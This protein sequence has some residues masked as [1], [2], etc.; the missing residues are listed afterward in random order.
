MKF[1]LAML[2]T[3]T[4]LMLNNLYA[5][6][7]DS[8]APITAS[9][10][11]LPFEISNLDNPVSLKIGATYTYKC[12]AR[13]ETKKP[14]KFFS[15]KTSSES[16]RYLVDRDGRLY[17]TFENVQFPHYVR[18]LIEFKDSKAVGSPQYSDNVSMMR[19]EHR[20][21]L[22]FSQKVYAEQIANN[23]GLYNVPIGQGA[24]LAFGSVCTFN[25]AITRNSTNENHMVV[26]RT[27]IPLGKPSVDISAIVFQV[28][29]AGECTTFDEGDV[30]MNL[31][32]W[33]AV[34]VETGETIG[35]EVNVVTSRDGKQIS[36]T[37]SSAR[38]E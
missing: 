19:K 37:T 11:K 28:E 36:E 24:Q 31:K 38:C 23:D 14:G 21:K 5:A 2:A 29:G 6:D 18:A 13:N 27:Q 34:A 20:E 16:R 15:E 33:R 26:G 4:Y 35:Y 8:A 9:L 7:N 3:L 17:K 22:E 1:T 10:P 32:G 30:H 12:K 25:N